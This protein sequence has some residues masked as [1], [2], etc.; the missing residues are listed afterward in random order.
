MVL[1]MFYI[2]DKDNFQ[3]IINRARKILTFCYLLYIYTNLNEYKIVS[4]CE[5]SKK[6][7]FFRKQILVKKSIFFL[8]LKIDTILYSFYSEFYAAS[9]S[10][11]FFMFTSIFL[12]ILAVK[13]WTK[14][15]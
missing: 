14:S 13:V 2:S 3:P 4:I 5:T 7:D 8:I 6:Y 15:Q 1:L 11:T 10:V 9:E 12:E